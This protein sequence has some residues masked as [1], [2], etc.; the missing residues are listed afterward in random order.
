MKKT[1]GKV[2]LVPAAVRSMCAP[3]QHCSG[4]KQGKPATA[5]RLPQAP[6][7]DSSAET[8]GASSHNTLAVLGKSHVALGLYRCMLDVQQF[9]MTCLS[10]H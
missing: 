5:S 9:Y 3:L 8:T 6:A 1:A 2:A 10:G 4:C 7:L